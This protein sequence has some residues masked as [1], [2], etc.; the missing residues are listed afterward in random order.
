[1]ADEN[2]AIAVEARQASEASKI[3]AE[4]KEEEVKILEHSV[5][6]LESTV[7]VLEKKVYELDEEVERHRFIRISLEHELQ[8]LRDRLSKVDNFV[9][10]H[11]VNSNAE[12]TEDHFSRQM[13]NRLLLLHEARDQIRILEREREELRVEIKQCK[14]YI[15]ELVLHSEAQAFQYQQKYKTLEAMIH[16]IKTDLPTSTSTVSTLDKNEKTSTRSRG[17][18][19][20]FRC[21]SSLVQ[22]MSSEKDQELSNARLRIEELEALSASRQ[23]EIYML[24]TRLAAAESMTHDVI[25][26]LLGVKLDM[27]NYANLIDQ[28][29]VQDLLKEANRQAEEFLAK[30]QEILKLR[31]QVTDFMEE[32]E[33]CLCEINKKDADILTAQVAL[34]QM[35]QRDQLL[36]AQ[37]EMLKM[38]KSN[39]IKRVAELDELIKT[40][41]GTTSSKEKHIRQIKEN[42]G[43][44]MGRRLVSQVGR[45]SSTGR[46]QLH[47]GQGFEAKYS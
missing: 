17:S 38:D 33:S 47:G 44:N 8:F 37:N 16:E 9:D 11:S 34:E 28:Q 6:E 31:K 19:S 25:R 22:Q 4:Q 18:S 46:V 14:E 43:V 35:Q 20:P 29:Q 42:G 41:E 5:E 24:N 30:E 36:S 39:L 12:Q 10:T 3:Y 23:K 2:E 21:I 45:S 27:T 32:K 1:M 26:D 7:N 40:Y 13:H 15:S